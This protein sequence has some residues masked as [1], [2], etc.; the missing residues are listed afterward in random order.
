MTTPGLVV[1]AFRISLFVAVSALMAGAC[2]KK[3]EITVKE[4]DISTDQVGKACNAGDERPCGGGVC[5]AGRCRQ[6]CGTD[7][8]CSG[9]ICLVEEAGGAGGCRLDDEADCAPDTPCST[10]LLACSIDSSCRIPCSD[11]LPC[12]R[13]DQKC[14]RGACFGSLEAG[15]RPWE[16]QT[17]SFRCT[18]EGVLEQ[19]NTR[20]AG[21]AAVEDCETEA[22]C[23][24]EAGRCDVRRCD[25][26]DTGCA[27]AALT[28]CDPAGDQPLVHE[29]CASDALC[30]AGLEHGA[31]AEPACSASDSRCEQG[32]LIACR[33]DRTGFD[34]EICASPGLCQQGLATGTCPSPACTPSALFCQGTEL[35]RCDGSGSGSVSLGTCATAALC[36]ASVTAGIQTCALPTCQSGPPS[37]FRG[38]LLQQCNSDQTGVE[39][40]EDCGA[41]GEICNPFFRRCEPLQ[42]TPL[43]NVDPP[44]WTMPT[45][46]I[47]AR[48]VSRYQYYQFMVLKA[49]G[50]NNLFTTDSESLTGWTFNAACTAGTGGGRPFGDNDATGFISLD[51]LA[52][53]GVAGALPMTDVDACDAN[54]YCETIGRNLCESTNPFFQGDF[55]ASYADPALD[56]WTYVCTAG[57][58][59]AYGYG[60]AFDSAAC[61]TSTPFE[62]SGTRGTCQSQAAG[63]TGVFDLSGNVPEWTGMC[64]RSPVAPR[65]GDTCRVRGGDPDATSSVPAADRT[66]CAGNAFGDSRSAESWA[67]MGFRCC[68]H[69]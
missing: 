16:C 41:A 15:D 53:P 47:E 25:V 55:V 38:A 37:C 40:I 10:A 44:G 57:G 12:P 42:K 17:E 27:G 8:E 67:G 54:L 45:Y 30:K 36:A 29:T 18:S 58:T 5:I 4:K 31:C 1:R 48:E 2:S 33:T 26:A 61:N 66:R 24:A 62:I 6:R 14:I 65:L 32:K 35:R 68:E 3:D 56:Y 13:N 60:S 43:V 39:T 28:F 11:S 23:D 19:C 50:A 9:S 7:A 34:E 69:P 52:D 46:Y 49:A 64:T 51:V 63:F 59:Q 22:L 20:A 21:W